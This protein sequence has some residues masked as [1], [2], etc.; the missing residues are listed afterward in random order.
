VPERRH[1]HQRDL[2]IFETLLDRRAETLDF[3]AEAYFGGVRK[4]AVNRL[5]ELRAAGYLQRI[6]LTVLDAPAP[7]NIYTL[8][9]K[10]RTALRLRSLAA[11]RLGGRRDTSLSQRS[12]PHQIATNRVG[13][14]LGAELIPEALIGCSGD[15]RHRPD[16]A[17]AARERDAHERG[18]VFV[19]VDL[20]HYSRARV[21]EKLRS[22]LGHEGARSILFITPDVERRAEV[23]R[24]VREA[25][26]EAVMQRVQP[27]TLDQVRDG[28]APLDPGTEP[29]RRPRLASPG[30]RRDWLA[31]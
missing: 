6:K 19:E 1:L 17:Y 3:L 28:S 5:G 22:F 8:A 13:D 7:Q 27:L 4:S 29:G 11:D 31:A 20:G 10:G 26:G 9:P 23:A 25:Y 14:W 18:L 2:A 16:A 21:L 12:I 30:R 24:W 15:R